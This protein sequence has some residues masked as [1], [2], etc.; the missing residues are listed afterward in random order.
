MNRAK[1]R[2]KKLDKDCYKA[3]TTKHEHG[4]H[5]TRVFCYGL[6]DASTEELIDECRHC[7]AN[8]INIELHDKKG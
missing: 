5:D 4:E 7:K 6:T 1:L 8:V 2:G 3:T